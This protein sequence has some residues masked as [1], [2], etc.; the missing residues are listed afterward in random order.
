MGRGLIKFD[1]KT[2]DLIA[3]KSLMLTLETE[4]GPCNDVLC[5]VIQKLT[6]EYYNDEKSQDLILVEQGS[7]SIYLKTAVYKS[8]DKGR[9]TVTLR[10]SSGK[11]TVKGFSYVS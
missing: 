3:G 4:S 6:V 9:E 7:I 8:I 5:Q 11:V 2:A 1:R 10:T